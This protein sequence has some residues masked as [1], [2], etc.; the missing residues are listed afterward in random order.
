MEKRDQIFAIRFIDDKTGWIVGNRGLMLNTLDG[1]K[2]WKKDS[3]VTEHAL[4]G[5]AFADGEGWIVGQ[6]GT[7]LHSSDG[8]K[9]WQ[10]QESNCEDSLMGVSF[11]NK[12]RGVAIGGGGTIVTTENG[13]KSWEKNPFDVTGF[14][15]DN[16]LE[17]GVVTL[18]FYSVFFL[19]SSHG[20]IVGDG[21]LVLFSSDGGKK[22]KVYSVGL[23]SNL[24][25]V[26]FRDALNGWAAGQNGLLLHTVDGGKRWEK[27]ET[28]TEDSLYRVCV[29][30]NFW[31]AAGANGAL[32]HSKDGKNWE[33]SKI[34][35]GVPP[36]SII[37][38][39]ILGTT[40][41]NKLVILVGENRIKTVH[42]K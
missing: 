31:V 32:L 41:S 19:D 35:L 42:L 25:S 8:G 5:I 27:A 29:K 33:K 39:S 37:D 20:W 14:L 30:E 22:W 9:S 15:P 12:Q 16:L 10:R 6:K 26:F 34:D 17:K 13:G 40:S 38:L 1:G 28:G 11:L 7:I 21:G 18:N 4:Y 36:P 2:T 24:F 23:F 3:P